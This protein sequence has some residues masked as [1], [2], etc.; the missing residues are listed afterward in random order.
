MATP[1]SPEALS[2]YAHLG[3]PVPQQAQ[4][5][6]SAYAPQP[7]QQQPLRPSPARQEYV[8]LIQNRMN[9][10][11]QQAGGVERVSRAGLMD[12]A[13]QKA[14]EDIAMLYGPAPT[15]EQPQK[16]LQVQPI[17]GT[18]KVMVYGAGMQS[19]QFIEAAKSAQ[20]AQM[21]PIFDAQGQPIPGMGMLNG[22]VKTFEAPQKAAE[23]KAK[24]ASENIGLAADVVSTVDNLLADENALQWAGGMTG[25]VLGK[26][27]GTT[28][29]I[30][31]KIE[32]LRDQIGL[33][34][35][36][37]IVGQGQ[38]SISDAEQKMAKEALAQV[39]TEGTDEQLIG[40]LK[41]VRQKFGGILDRLQSE[42][43]GMP[44]ATTQPSA[45]PQKRVFVPG[46]GFQ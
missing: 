8:G 12:I 10:L 33:F 25:S 35:R 26:F 24:A 39:I 32:Q 30:R 28:S 7:M 4:P 29:G 1:L 20:P 22:E 44:A 3:I 23:A 6:V 38:G 46:K 2:Y 42:A 13:R 27:P 34:G 43:Q 31:Q 36:K 19:P 5:D 40:S 16:P 15:I 41:A 14:M 45:A 9:E 18:E 11:I 21:Q 17:P 37:A